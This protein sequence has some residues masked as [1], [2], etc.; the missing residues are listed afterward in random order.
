MKSKESLLSQV[1]ETMLADEYGS[2]LSRQEFSLDVRLIL[3]GLLKVWGR[4]IYVVRDRTHHSASSFCLLRS[5]FQGRIS[6]KFVTSLLPLR[7][8]NPN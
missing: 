1:A 4:M 5:I 8:L 7:W 2:A 3:F 6:F